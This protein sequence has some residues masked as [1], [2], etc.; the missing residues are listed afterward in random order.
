MKRFS[1]TL[2]AFV[3]TLAMLAQGMAFEPEGTTLEQASAKAKAENKL[4]FLDCFTQ[5][6]GPCKKMA[7]DV[8]PQEQV[9][10]Y[11]NP[12]FV[13]LQ[14]DME[15]EYGAPL[16]KKLQIQAYPTFVIFNADAQEIGRFLGGSGAE[17][18]IAKVDEKSKDNSSSDLKARWESGDRDPQ[19]LQEYLASLNAS[20]K[21]D[22]ADLVAEAILEGKEA[23]FAADSVLRMI[24]MRSIN[25]PFAT[26]F[27]YTA[28]N[29]A[30]LKAQIGEMP[31]NMKIQSVLNN[32]QRQLINE[33]DG[34]ATLNQEQFD[35]FNALLADLGVKNA[36]HYR[37]STLITLSDKQKNYDNYLSYIREY[38]ANPNLDADDMQ[39]ARWVKPFSDPSADTN[40][41]AQMKEILQ[42]RLADIRSGKRQSQSQV[43]NMKLSRPTDELLEMLVG[44]MDG[45]VPGQQ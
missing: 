25:N 11:M 31:V 17:E 13:N 45:N 41:K 7:R 2:T 44:A 5:W 33:A 34:T 39:L 6:C 14:I 12:K 24:F 30:D 8:F 43:G 40:H 42:Q 21:N 3:A 28:K 16:A 9:G 32:Y 27:I 19:F 35:R 18:F 22:E 36:D 1:L 15:S 20:Y 4:I 38:L 29:P 23:T 10:A 37:L 26:S